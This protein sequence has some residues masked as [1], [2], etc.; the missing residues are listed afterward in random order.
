MNESIGKNNWK[1]VLLAMIFSSGLAAG[2]AVSRMKSGQEEPPPATSWLQ[3]G[4]DL[5][6]TVSVQ[7]STGPRG[8]ALPGK[9]IL[10]DFTLTDIEG[11]DVQIYQDGV[12]PAVVT[13]FLIGC[14]DCQSAFQLFP[15]L[16]KE[17]RAAGQRSV[18]VAYMGN[19]RKIQ[20][21]FK[22]VDFAGPVYI[23]KGSQLQRHF[24]IGTF[25]VWLL[26][27]DGTILHQ[28]SPA[29]VQPFLKVHL[30]NRAGEELDQHLAG[31]GDGYEEKQ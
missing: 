21:T 1:L 12:A 14:P 19:P 31:R 7:I 30:A 26:A 29:S 3:E 5:D 4:Q 13:E 17:I 27:A 18:N 22:K 28:G 24:R 9:V 11:K 16:A 2:F 6:Q 8:P 15:S 10:P 23:D 25:T 20:Q